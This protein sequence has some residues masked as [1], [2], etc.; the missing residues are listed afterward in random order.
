M[1][2]NF[3]KKDAGPEVTFSESSPVVEATSEQSVETDPVVLNGVAPENLYSKVARY[4][5]LAAVFLVPLF[6][7]PITTGILELNK[8]ILLLLLTGVALVLWLLSIVSSGYLSIRLNSMDRGVGVFALVTLVATLFSITKFNSLFGGSNSLSDSLASILIFSIAYFLIVNL[9]QDGGKSVKMALASALG[10]AFIFGLL[11]MFGLH[12]L[13]FGPAVSKAFYSVGSLNSLGMLAAV[14]IP[15]LYRAKFELPIPYIKGEYVS[16]TALVLGLV[17][18]FVI[19]WWALWVVAI[20][21]IVALVALESLNVKRQFRILKFI[22][23]M[24]VIVLAVFLM[25]IKFNPTFKRD[26][27]V[28][29]APSYQITLDMAKSVLKEKFILGYGPENYSVAFDKFGSKYLSN[30]TLSSTQFFDSTAQAFNVVFSGGV[31]LSLAFIFLL[32]SI[33]MVVVSYYKS[34]IR[35]YD[36]FGENDG[37]ISSALAMTV[38][39]FMYPFNFS[40]MF[41]FYILLALLVLAA[42]G[43]KQKVYSIERSPLL[44][45]SASLGFIGGLILVLVGAYM[46]LSVFMA[47][48]KYAQALAN[49][50]SDKRA[51]IITEAIGWNGKNFRH[52]MT[53]SQVALDLLAKEVSSKEKNT[54]ERLSRMQNFSSSAV[55]FAKKATELAPQETKA[56]ENL[57]VVYQNLLTLVDGAD[58]LAEDALVKAAELRPGDAGYYNRIGTMYLTESDLLRQIAITNRSNQAAQASIAALKKSEENFQKAIAVS[59]N[60]G[61]AIY[62]LGAVYDRQGRLNEAVSQLE[63][64]AP[65]NSNQAG[66]MFELGLLY[67]RVGKKDQAIGQLEKAVLIAPDYANA[68][69]YLALLYEEKG[70]MDS[71]IAQLERILSVDVNKDNTLVTQKLDQLK[72]GVQTV[73]PGKALDEKPL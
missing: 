5:L 14:S 55:S 33:L 63:K 8:L 31:L 49:K 47:D 2:L 70:N 66:L 69:W 44:S 46:G 21:G 68:R 58:K 15:F 11:Q 61:L 42:Y 72:A 30:S 45:L 25:I 17:V 51:E 20:T 52:Y 48:V 73:K 56:W 50:E 18:L 41:V 43:N 12:V 4:F 9:Y 24:T 62:N 26:L 32:A 36:E 1:R 40:L 60:F 34:E 28:E 22:F 23:P 37:L 35:D 10:L 27:P 65:F 19:N 67:Y 59:N 16:K 57:G 39:L 71:A 7:L 54:P 38:G 6:F 3:W 13:R 64:I 53:L 29:V